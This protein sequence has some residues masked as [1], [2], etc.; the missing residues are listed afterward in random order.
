MNQIQCKFKLLLFFLFFFLVLI[1]PNI[2]RKN[3]NKTR[4]QN[5]LLVLCLSTHPLHV[6]KSIKIQ[7]NP[8]NTLKNFKFTK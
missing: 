2:H 1:I 7:T 4:T 6:Y 5:T 8:N 3:N